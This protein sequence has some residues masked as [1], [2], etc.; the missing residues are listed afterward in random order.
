MRRRWLRLIP[1]VGIAMVLLP[2]CSGGGSDNSPGP[3][4]IVATPP[5]ALMDVPVQMAVTG[6]RPGSTVT[7]S[8]EATDGYGVRWSSHVDLPADAEG[9][10]SLD[11]PP[12]GGSYSGAHSMGLLTTMAPERSTGNPDFA[13]GVGRTF[14]SCCGSTRKAGSSDRPL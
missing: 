4:Q 2:S 5:T 14:R 9:T 7:V 1:A 13:L 10:A 6:L 8:A 11:Q 12:T 3:V